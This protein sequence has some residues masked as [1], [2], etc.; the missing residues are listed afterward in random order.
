MVKAMKLAVSYE[1]GSY[2]EVDKKM[3]QDAIE[4]FLKN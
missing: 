1:A 4:N 2:L 3:N